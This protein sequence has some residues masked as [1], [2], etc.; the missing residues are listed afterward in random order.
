MPPHP[1]G[2]GTLPRASV[3]VS[4]AETASLGRLFFVARCRRASGANHYYNAT[5]LPTARLGGSSCSTM[6]RFGPTLGPR[7]DGGK[8]I[9]EAQR[10]TSTTT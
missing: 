4:V 1:P 7:G 2:F 9:C 6:T 10:L 8:T 3:Y 5:W